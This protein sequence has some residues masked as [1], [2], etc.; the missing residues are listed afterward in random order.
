MLYEVF[1][2]IIMANKIV[3][4]NITQEISIVKNKF[5]GRI[6]KVEY[7]LLLLLLP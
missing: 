5:E 1:Y 7:K 3:V 6:V 4:F 2:Y